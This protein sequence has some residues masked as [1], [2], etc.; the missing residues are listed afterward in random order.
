LTTDWFAVRSVLLQDAA[1]QKQSCARDNPHAVEVGAAGINT[2][3]SCYVPIHATRLSFVRIGYRYRR[4]KTDCRSRIVSLSLLG[5]NAPGAEPVVLHRENV[6]L[7]SEA[8]RFFTFPSVTAPNPC[9]GVPG[10]VTADDVP[11]GEARFPQESLPVFFSDSGF[12]LGVEISIV[13][14]RD[15]FVLGPIGVEDHAVTLSSVSPVDFGAA[16][17]GVTDDSDALESAVAYA[18]ANHLPLDLL[19]RTYATSRT[20]HL[21]PRQETGDRVVLR[22]G[23]I[24]YLGRDAAAVRV[25]GTLTQVQMDDVAITGDSSIGLDAGRAGSSTFH[26]VRIEGSFE[27][28]LL[29]A[30]GMSNTFSDCSFI[31]NR[32]NARI[33]QAPV[34]GFVS[35]DNK[36]W[37]CKFL[38]SSGT[39][40]LEITSRANNAFHGCN[41]EHSAQRAV[42]INGGH[43]NSFID[44]RFEVSSVDTAAEKPWIMIDIGEGRSTRIIN[45]WMPGFLPPERTPTESDAYIRID[46]SHYGVQIFGTVFGGPEHVLNDPANIAERFGNFHLS[47]SFPVPE[48]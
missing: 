34:G 15:S 38:R 43:G 11:V 31:G 20:I 26:R 7:N 29:L 23:N 16:A 33:A 19:H 24:R 42:S 40:S 44:C 17:N 2:T 27:V 13:D 45:C 36:F 28:G 21:T 10:Q 32:V 48:R 4:W 1:A 30:G 22:C 41:F 37:N 3:K 39:A 14:H 12:L 6:S 47:N 18:Y 25:G 46:P 8:Y 5:V 9:S 35:N